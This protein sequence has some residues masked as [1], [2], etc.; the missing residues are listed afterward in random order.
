LG[1]K[2]ISTYQGEMLTVDRWLIDNGYMLH[3]TSPT[4]EYVDSVLKGNMLKKYEKTD[5]SFRLFLN[6][7]KERLSL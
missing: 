1:Q 4:K 6:L 7:M 5:K 2:V 3:N